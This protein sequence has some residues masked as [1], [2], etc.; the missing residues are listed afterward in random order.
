[1]PKLVCIFGDKGGTGKSTWARAVADLYRVRGVRAALFDGD[2]V[3]RS[4][5]RVYGARSDQGGFVPLDQQDPR[6]GCLLYDIQNKKY[7]MD[8]LI[9][10]LELPDTQ[11]VFHDLPA[12]VRLEF[13]QLM[14]LDRPDLAM[15]EFTVAARHLGVEPVFVATLTPARSTQD[16]A[17]WLIDTL[18][19]LATV[20]A[21]RNHQYGEEQFAQWDGAAGQEAGR[22]RRTRFLS[23]GG[24]ET[25]MPYLDPDTFVRCEMTAKRWSELIDSKE[26]TAADRARISVW[27]RLFEE[28][29]RKVEDSLG[30]VSGSTGPALDAEA[31]SSSVL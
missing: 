11:V 26:V 12:G 2:W 20:I 17:I 19:D 31:T 27:R 6:R 1:M 5:F 3:S 16:T 24:R 22:G 18:G 8:F 25:I 13:M 9:N 28:E 15:R 30:F 23:R 10:S 4:L 21:V 14:G 29:I 7:G